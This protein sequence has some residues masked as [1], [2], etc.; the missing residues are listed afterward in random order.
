MWKNLGWVRMGTFAW[1]SS[2]G[3]CVACGSSSDSGASAVL[4]EAPHCP[5][6]TDALKI[7]G[8]IGDAVIDDTRTSNLN[9]GYENIGMPKFSTP[10]ST[11]AMLEPNQLPITITWAQSLF[12]GQTG[13]ITGGTLTLPADQPNA[14]A[15]FCI[16]A[17]EVGFVSGGS[18]DGA[19]KFVV[20]QVKSGADC[21]GAATAVDLRGCYQ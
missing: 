10:L 20:T 13:A 21:S 9:A 3:L 7:E 16:S 19:F 15:T 18:E 8:A 2:C 5:S 4:T 12:D 6:G 17:G 11:L 1:I 14:S